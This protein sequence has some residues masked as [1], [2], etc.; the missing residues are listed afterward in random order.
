M[1]VLMGVLMKTNAH[2]ETL[3]PSDRPSVLSGTLPVL[4]TPFLAGKIDFDSLSRL[5]DFIFPALDGYT[6][7]GSTGEAVSMTIDE[8][9]ELMRFAA[10]NT[11]VGKKIVVGLTHT[12]LEDCKVLAREASELG[13]Q[14]GLIPAPYYFPN[15]FDMVREFLRALDGASDLDLVYY[16]NPVF[17]KTVL[18]SADILRLT[19]ACS[20]LKAVKMTDHDLEKITALRERGISVFAGDDIVA[21]RSLLLGVDGSMIIAPAVLPTAYQST[22]GLI[23]QNDAEGALRLFSECI[24]P[25]IH[26]FGPGDEIPVTKAIYYHLGVFA[27][28][29]LRLPLLP[30]T[31][32]RFKQVLL[33]YEFCQSRQFV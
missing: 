1:S 19:A 24:L 3:L 13:I 4:P 16:H 26:L 17:T 5:F 21:F 9:L 12:N 33:A 32:E 30:P 28:G 10:K 20:H 23:A 31:P 27:S 14:A 29:E 22:V 6:L 2:V 15:S 25:F 11:P 7:G 8:R 18:T